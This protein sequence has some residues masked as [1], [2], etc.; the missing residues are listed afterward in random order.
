MAAI[1]LNLLPMKFVSISLL[2]SLLLITSCD[3]SKKQ[4][5]NQILKV[6][7]TQIT[8]FRKYLKKLQIIQLPFYYKGWTDDKIDV[9]NLY[10]LDKN[11]NDT[12][13]FD[14]NDEN[15]KC[16]GVLS[17]TS[18][19]FSIVYFKIG[20]APVPILAIYS[21]VGKLLDKQ[22]LLCYGCGSDCGLE[23]C[24]YT[25][26]ITKTLDIYIADTA[27]YNGLCDSLQEDVVKKIDS[28]FINYKTGKIETNG[29]IMIGQMI[30]VR[31]KNSP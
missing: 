1:L 27:I 25:A 3:D 11:S 8:S 16:Y 4:N 20:D 17:D 23:Y 14:I 12:L 31:K 22:E 5:D 28:T 19:Y 2:L 6:E 7:T 10:T 13:F 18:N 29:K 15:I 21:K 30:N 9:G 26:Q 24:S